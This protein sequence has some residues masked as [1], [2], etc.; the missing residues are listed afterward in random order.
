MK[1]LRFSLLIFIILT[2]CGPEM[3]GGPGAYGGQGSLTLLFV[4][5]MMVIL[6]LYN[7]IVFISLRETSYLYL[8]VIPLLYCIYVALFFIL[9]RQ[10]ATDTGSPGPLAASAI[11]S[12]LSLMTLTFVQFSRTFHGT[13]VRLPGTDRIM[14]YLMIIVSLSIPLYFFTDWMGFEINQYIAVATA[15]GAIVAYLPALQLWKS[16]QSARYFLFSIFF[17]APFFLTDILTIFRGARSDLTV[18]GVVLLLLYL[19]FG[20]GRNIQRLMRDR[21]EALEAVAESESRYRNI[22]DNAEEGIF[23]ADFEG[24]I[25][26]ANKSLLGMLG[27][28]S[29]DDI[30]GFDPVAGKTVFADINERNETYERLNR[31]GFIKNKEVTLRKKNGDTL[32][33]KLSAR[34]VTH[35]ETGERLVD[36]VLENISEWKKS[37]DYRLRTEKK[38]KKIFENAAEGIFQMT[39]EGLLLV[40]NPALARLLGYPSPEDEVF[41]NDMIDFTSV[42]SDKSF[43]SRAAEELKEPEKS[44]NYETRLKRKGGDEIWVSVNIASCAN[45]D[46]GH[47]VYEGSIQNISERHRA[48]EEIERGKE[49]LEERVKKRTQKLV[50]VNTQ[51]SYEIQ[52]REKTEQALRRSEDRYRRLIETM[53]EGFVVVNRNQMVTYVN[54][55]I[56]EM[57]GYSKAELIGL[58]VEDFA[59]IVEYDVLQKIFVTGIHDGHRHVELEVPGKDGRLVS[60]IVSPQIMKT[61]EGDFD[62]SFSVVTDITDIRDARE[63]LINAVKLA[64]QANK[65]KSEFLANISH[66]IRTPLNAIL[67]FADLLLGGERDATEES[68][69]EAIRKGGKSLMTL[70]NDILDLSRIESGRI[71]IHYDVVDMQKLGMEIQDIFSGEL[72]SKK[73]DFKIL[74]QPELFPRLFFDEVR[75]RQILFNLIGNAIKFTSEGMIQVVF[76][77]EPEEGQG[78]RLTI[79]VKDTGIG[80]HAEALEYI[81]EAFSQQDTSI[82]RKFGGTGLGL[83]ITR[84]LV[85][86]MNGSIAVESTEGQGAL[87]TVKFEGLVIAEGENIREEKRLVKVNKLSYSKTALVVDDARDNRHFLSEVLRKKGLKVIEAEDGAEA[88]EVLAK[89]HVD[90]LF[91]DIRMPLLDGFQT[92]RIIRSDAGGE[93]LPVIA[94]SASVIDDDTPEFHSAGFNE[95]LKKPFSI[96]EVHLIL[97]KYFN[98]GTEKVP[99]GGDAVP[100][101]QDLNDG[102]FPDDLK[103]YLKEH[104][105][106]MIAT[107][108]AGGFIADVENLGEQLTATALKFENIMLEELGNSL[109]AASESI[110]I[111]KINI[112]L[113]KISAIAGVKSDD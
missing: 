73:L 110:D 15:G 91:L 48:S 62:G 18:Y 63:K 39:P 80:I 86:I 19:S 22:F 107:C 82:T 16:E 58:N 98:A 54:S 66:E 28:E 79:A 13:P 5:G 84:R 10:T 44:K 42:F 36:G 52:E 27:V 105:L 97:E 30:P 88:L 53:N 104:F 29:I 108:R 76:T 46:T 20:V 7:M 59:N 72:K 8:A 78:L 21:D 41:I 1:E 109:T 34:I 99:P 100:V 83:A 9:F 37:E 94:V 71:D 33:V 65:A 49:K 67:G 14:K 111:E 90:I 93:V 35:R 43:F 106:P 113:E 92:A 40:A 25:L 55:R 2:G 103:K 101:N 87:F 17:I 64:E 96:K 26:L 74:S 56:C 102:D 69:L 81:F 11:Y 3:A 95:Y 68:Y 12:T 60:A 77:A 75:L 57:S 89:A 70:V 38:Y 32:D 31:V 50:R 47:L 6:F 112:L 45:E 24:R 4:T 23:Q 85:E 51:L 61:E